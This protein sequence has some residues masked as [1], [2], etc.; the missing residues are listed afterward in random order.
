MPKI[1]L[2][3]TAQVWKET[4]A[5]YSP[6]N[7]SIKFDSSQLFNGTPQYLTEIFVA[8]ERVSDFKTWLGG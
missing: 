5:V 1:L 7:S 4:C 3:H 6:Y 2:N 8:R